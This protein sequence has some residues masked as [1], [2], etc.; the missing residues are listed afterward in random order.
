MIFCQVKLSCTYY[1]WGIR[2]ALLFHHLHSWISRSCS[3][4]DVTSFSLVRILVN[5]LWSN[6]L[7]LFNCIMPVLGT[8]LPITHAVDLVICV[9]YI[10]SCIHLQAMIYDIGFIM[11]ALCNRGAIIFLPCSF[12]LLLLLSSSSFFSSRNLS[13]RRLDVC[14]TSTHGVALVR[15]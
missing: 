9:H 2:I 8:K 3:C 13:G 4:V 1:N 5:H 15:I 6:V 10:L 12:F 14:H 11:A 7:L